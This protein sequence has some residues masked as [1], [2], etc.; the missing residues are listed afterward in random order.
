[1]ITKLVVIKFNKDI[2]NSLCYVSYKEK[3][4]DYFYDYYNFNLNMYRIKYI[5]INLHLIFL[6][7]CFLKLYLK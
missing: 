5:L 6:K 2:K 7:K 4:K 3:I 1:V